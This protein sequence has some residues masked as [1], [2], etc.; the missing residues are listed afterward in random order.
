MLDL[1]ILTKKQKE[2]VPLVA[3]M[4]SRF[5]LV[6]GTALALQM[7]HRRSIDF[8]LFSNKSFDN[9]MIVKKIEERFKINKI[10]VDSK[11]ELT[12]MVNQIKFICF[13]QKG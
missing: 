7:G 13:G 12:M 2:L 8:D 5:Y 1:R 6:G 3:E 9:K 11:D 10:F 4:N